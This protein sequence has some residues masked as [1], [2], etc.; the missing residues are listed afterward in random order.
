MTQEALKGSDIESQL[1]TAAIVG[2]RI[3]VWD[4]EQGSQLYAEAFYGKPLGIRK[5]KSP[6]FT[7]PLELS[8]LEAKYLQEKNRIVVFNPETGE[9]LDGEAL[10]RIAHGYYEMFDD[11]YIVYS[12]LRENG[13]VVR[14]GL[15]FGCDMAVYEQGPGIDH[16]PFLVSAV[17]KGIELSP[18][19]LVRAGRLATSVRKRFVIAMIFENNNV[20]YYAFSWFKP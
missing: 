13:Y 10:T 14:P 5:P 11:L 6:H 4:P 3:I 9:K 12:D 7:V 19:Q 16:S 17:P 18:I 8:F 20:K 1:I 2:S 15:K